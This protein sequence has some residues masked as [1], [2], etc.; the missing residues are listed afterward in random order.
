MHHRDRCA[1][2]CEEPRPR[3]SEAGG[4]SQRHGEDTK[5]V[6]PQVPIAESDQD[7]AGEP[8]QSEDSGSTMRASPTHQDREYPR[9]DNPDA[10]IPVDQ[11]A[12]V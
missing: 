12:I 9:Q 11:E 7:Q 3:E 10:A 5:V 8:H 4:D 6:A 1:D 2:G